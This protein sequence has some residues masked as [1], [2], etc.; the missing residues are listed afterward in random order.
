MVRR[1]WCALILAVLLFAAGAGAT[2]LWQRPAWVFNHVA[3]SWLNLDV[4]VGAIEW[5]VTE[6]RL[7]LHLQDVDYRSATPAPAV[8][9][10]LEHVAVDVRL[11]WP[12]RITISQL[13]LSGGRVAIVQRDAQSWWRQIG[14]ATNSQP[15]GSPAWMV[16]L[17]GVFLADTRVVVE[18]PQ[19][20]H[21]LVLN[22]A[23]SG[24]SLQGQRWL[25]LQG[26]V[27]GNPLRA[28]GEVLDIDQILA[29]RAPFALDFDVDIAG[30]QFRAKGKLDLFN[31]AGATRVS[32]AADAASLPRF[33]ALFD[34]DV[35]YL[36]RASM[37]AL[38][39]DSADG[40]RLEDIAIGLQTDNISVDLT[41]QVSHPLRDWRPELQV[42][43]DIKSL[44]AT[45]ARFGVDMP[46]DFSV[47]LAGRLTRPAD[48]LQLS[49]ADGGIT[50]KGFEVPGARQ[51]GFSNATIT[52][53]K[54]ELRGWGG[55]F[56]LPLDIT[57]GALLVAM[58]FEDQ[59]MF[60]DIPVSRVGM[61]IRG[62]GMDLKGRGSFK[63]L[64]ID[65]AFGMAQDWDQLKS[66][67]LAPGARIRIDSDLT[68]PYLPLDVD[69][70]LTE[71]TALN[72]WLRVALPE[73]AAVDASA[74][75]RIAEDNTVALRRLRVKA[76]ADG[77][78][79]VFMPRY[80]TSQPD[81]VA[82][83]IAAD[84]PDTGRMAPFLEQV[85]QYV[86]R[87]RWQHIMGDLSTRAADAAP[88]DRHHIPA[89]LHG[90]L[91]AQRW[92]EGRLNLD[93]AIEYG[94]G[95]FGAKDLTLRFVGPELHL[96]AAGD[97]IFADRKPVADLQLSAFFGRG[98]VLDLPVPLGLNGRVRSKG[99]TLFAEDIEL[100]S[101]KS[102]LRLNASL[103]QPFGARP[104][105]VASAMVDYWRMGELLDELENP[106]AGI[107]AA[108]SKPASGGGQPGASLFPDEPLDLGLL[109]R[110]DAYVSLRGS[111]LDFRSFS[112][113]DWQVDLALREGS[114]TVQ[115]LRLNTLGGSVFGSMERALSGDQSNWKVQL[116]VDGL[117]LSQL[118]QTGEQASR[119]AVSAWVDLSSRGDTPRAI[120]ANLRGRV[121]PYATNLTL[122]GFDLDRLV[123]DFLR[124][125]QRAL[126]AALQNQAGAGEPAQAQTRIECAAAQLLFADGLLA[127]D[128][129]IH[130]RTRSSTFL[131]TWLLDLISEQQRIQMTPRVRGGIDLGGA[132]LARMV[133]VTGTLRKPSLEV[134]PAGLFLVGAES[135]ALYAT[136]G[137]LYYLAWRQIE[138]NLA[139]QD[140]CERV[141][142]SYLRTPTA[143]LKLPVGGGGLPGAHKG[144]AQ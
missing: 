93:T 17:R 134:D 50:F 49:A 106:L 84:I 33:A 41:G 48:F 113:R 72:R 90:E 1:R 67:T 133:Q 87:E 54:D 85:V 82:A 139:R 10:S 38:L 64:P 81:R 32:L 78:V 24:V 22:H 89:G 12:R 95:T 119:G 124:S 5:A 37:R 62:D 42:A 16:R 70:H 141:G 60:Y 88:P 83:H 75:V 13:Y 4:S 47:D 135:A 110:L 52:L 99:G 2:L 115:P 129:S 143:R 122:H 91:T 128:R 112:I 109:E 144:Q 36:H 92:Y 63:G 30:L 44:Q 77:R 123:P 21:E 35:P 74:E 126:Q 120:A 56:E 14:G 104:R 108:A 140:T 118:R 96:G 116:A 103:A 39:T 25:Q 80:D 26:E 28:Q 138:N 61:V 65:V 8:S 76:E 102:A 101:G 34:I 20:T 142:T 97:F 100:Q 3:G 45:L 18:S 58:E 6:G 79:E 98:A 40:F 11:E 53:P 117:D 15:R 137:W 59:L 19:Q 114:L 55:P 7:L 71:A 23:S 125:T 136:G 73:A 51:F 66:T 107:R 29:Q 68:R 46:V 57:A 127:A 132:N 121:S 69:L 105:L 43:I 86:N 31:W 9:V 131:I 94:A 111:E 130:V 27:D